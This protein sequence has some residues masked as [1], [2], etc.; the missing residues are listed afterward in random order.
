AVDGTG[1]GGDIAHNI[2]M[3]LSTATGEYILATPSNGADTDELSGIW[4]LNRST[5]TP[6]AGLD[7]PD[8]TGT[9]WI[10]EGW[11]VVDGVPVTSG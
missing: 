4:Y 1:M 10:Y 2:G 7:L 6:V 9:D 8:L 11:V 5:G 3:D